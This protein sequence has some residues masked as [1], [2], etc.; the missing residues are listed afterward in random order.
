[1]LDILRRGNAYKNTRAVLSGGRTSI[2]CFQDGR[3]VEF[4]R[5]QHRQL[6]SKYHHHYYHHYHQPCRRRGRFFSS[7]TSSSSTKKS[8]STEWTVDGETGIVSHQGTP[9]YQTLLGLEIHAQLDISTKLFSGCAVKASG[10]SSSS[11]IHNYKPNTSVFPLDMAVPGWL[12]RL[13]QEAVHAG[14]LSAAALHCDLP[15]VSRFERKHYFYADLPLGY[16]MTQQRWPLARNGVLHCQRP[17]N[18]KKKRNN[19]KNNKNAIASSSSSS[20]A[21][22][23]VSIDRIQLEQDTGKTILATNPRTQQKESLVDFNRAG[24]AL[25]EIVFAPELTS[26]VD[27]ATAVETLR[28]LLKHIGSCNGKLEEGSLRCDVNVSISP[29][30]DN[31]EFGD[32]SLSQQQQLLLERAG[33]R[34]EV[35]NLNSLRQIQEAAKYEAVRQAQAAFQRTPT[36][37]E[38]R[39]FDAKT[40]RTI[41]TRTKGGAKDYRFM[42]EPDLPPLVLNANVLD[43]MTVTEFISARLPE[44]PQDARERLQRD[45][46]LSDYMATVIVGDPP[47]IAMFDEAM[48]VALSQLTDGDDTTQQQQ[49]QQQQLQRQKS[50]IS[51]AIANLLCNELFALVREFE[52]R[53]LIAEGHLDAAGT[54]S[55]QFS[56]ITGTQLGNVVVLL[57]E[58][59]MSNTMAKQLLR[60]LY[61]GHDELQDVEPRQ[62]ASDRGF[63]L[64][65]DPAI[66]EE[67]CRK[68]IAEHTD[69]LERYKLGG[70]FAKKITK[71]FL[72]KAMAASQGNAHPERLNE[73]LME[74]LEDI[75]PLED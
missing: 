5:I 72:G 62:V 43:G 33:N 54:T 52:T 75:A 17:S 4:I 15:P 42:P 48:Q 35:K 67:L 20:S 22:F 32:S 18:Q 63:A 26:P 11:S 45:Y 64:I 3:E 46:G 41:V 36:A 71:F 65:T 51:E 13:S 14:V 24:Q 30:D 38:T 19:N 61:E 40:G 10:S 39:T 69:E 53:R 1:M 2:I 23:S 28:L 66:I 49:Q 73:I 6:H 59:T 29:I 58:G 34:V 25:I 8:L 60:V 56:K 16:Q 57:L 31:L 27:A 68:V 12:P 44:L 37:Q 47:A 9:R 74:V 55:V 70:K 7:S 50:K 21:T